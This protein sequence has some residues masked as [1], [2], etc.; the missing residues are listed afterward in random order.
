MVQNGGLLQRESVIPSFI[1][2]CLVLISS[3]HRLY[4]VTFKPD[5]TLVSLLTK[6]SK[7]FVLLMLR[8][9]GVLQRDSY[10][11]TSLHLFTNL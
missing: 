11:R 5:F 9:G 4:A 8:N 2:I 1:C 6:L 7:S 3:S 10:L